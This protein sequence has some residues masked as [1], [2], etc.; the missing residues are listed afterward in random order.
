M[1]NKV[2]SLDSTNRPWMWE[3]ETYLPAQNLGDVM[4]PLERPKTLEGRQ[5]LADEKVN[6]LKKRAAWIF[7]L[8]GN[9]D[10]VAGDDAG[11]GP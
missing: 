6:E 7:D 1:R 5:S 8:D 11:G 4:T 10:L 3:R 2:L 9:S